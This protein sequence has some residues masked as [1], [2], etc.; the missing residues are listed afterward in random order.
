MNEYKLFLAGEWVETRSGKI[1]DDINPADGSVYARV[2]TAGPEEVETAIAKAVEAQ[3]VWISLLPEQ[4]EKVLL[5][6][7]DHME[8]NIDRYVQ[9][10][11]EES[12]SCYIKSLDEVQQT[13]NIFRT[14]AGECRRIDGGIVPAEAG[15]EMSYWKRYP[16]GVVAGISPFNYPL[17]LSANKVALALAAGN[18]CILKPA[19][20]TPLAGIIIAECLEAGGLTKGLYSNV[21]GS[22]SLIG[23]MLIED[24]RIRMIAFTGST[25]VGA[26]LAVKCAAHM[27]RIAL[28]LGGKNPVIVLKDAD[29]DKAVEACLFGAFF[30]QGQICMASNRLIVEKDVYDVFCEKLLARVKALKAGDPRD[31][32]NMVGPLIREDHCKVIDDQIS[33]AVSKGA[34]LLCGGTHEGT[35]YHPTMV[36]DVTPEMDIFYEECFGPVAVVTKAEDAED[37]LALGNNNKYGLVASVMTNDLSI[38]MDF[39]DRMEAGI[40]HVNDCTVAGSRRAPFGG[41]KRSGL[42]RENSTFSVEEFM[43][44]KWITIRYADKEF[45]PM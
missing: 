13:V 5:R 22:S 3:K 34:K 27:K 19:S 31:P 26:E 8:E 38:A 10:L 35:L 12:G 25:K 40:V 2:H 15:G 42:G 32:V 18:A 16:L 9:M 28:E 7:A 29:I 23:D 24:D 44:L 30:H 14:A 11:I 17:I 43:E 45:P 6:A 4:R 39:V 36:V 20:D 37:A 33:D 21:P 1:V 41:T